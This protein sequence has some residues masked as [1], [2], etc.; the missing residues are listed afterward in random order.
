MINTYVVV[1][2]NKINRAT[3]SLDIKKKKNHYSKT[4]L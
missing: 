4:S 2:I 3:H 1:N